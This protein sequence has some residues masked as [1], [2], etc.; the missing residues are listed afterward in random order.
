[1][2]NFLPLIVLV[3]L[4]PDA[5][6]FPNVPAPISV[7]NRLDEHLRGLKSDADE[8]RLRAVTGIRELGHWGRPA[9]PALTA[10]LP[11]ASQQSAKQ[12]IETLGALGP[13]ARRSLPVLLDIVRQPRNG[14]VAATAI[15]IAEIGEPTNPVMVRACLL[16]A[17]RGRAPA[18]L[19]LDLM[20][21]YPRMAAVVADHLQD[22]VPQVRLNA[23][24]AV[25]QHFE[26]EG[27][28]ARSV[29]E[30]LPSGLRQRIKDGLV[31]ALGDS[32]VPVR[33]W[34]I[35]AFMLFE[36]SSAATV[37]PNWIT[38]I[39]RNE[40]YSPGQQGL[41]N[42]GATGARLVIDYLDDPEDRVRESLIQLLSSFRP[43][44]RPTLL[45]AMKHPNPRV[46]EGVIRAVRGSGEPVRAAVEARLI[47][48]DPRVRRAAATA[49]ASINP[50]KARAAIPILVEAAFERDTIVRLNALSTLEIMATFARP[51]VPDMLRRAHTGDLETRFAAAR[52]LAAADRS[53]W[54]TFVPVFID[55]C[56]DKNGAN[57][58]SAARILKSIGP[59]AK[60]ALPA[61]KEMFRDDQAMNRILAADAYARIAPKEVH[62]A[63]KCLIEVLGD[64]AIGVRPRRGI[65]RAT[66]RVLQ[67]LGPV[68]KD[69][70]PALLEVMRSEENP[71][72]GASA[73]IAVIKID[74]ASAAEVYDRFRAE[75]NPV[76]PEPEE[77]WLDFMIQ[78]GKLAKPLIPQMIL[79]L[80]SGQS[81]QQ[82]PV[83]EVLTALGPDA[84]EAIPAL[85]ELEKK[86]KFTDEVAA[87]IKS[88]SGKK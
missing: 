48:E 15:A 23:A 71:H 4:P 34:C 63:V 61:L 2:R 10:L 28:R 81:V 51:A 41:V 27:A 56:H 65:H 24:V 57:R 25:Y 60:A 38:I 67:D 75:L 33:A 83:L 1:M 47:D 6:S 37:M 85:R 44:A 87:A 18:S 22:P 52:V 70:V 19:I 21:R 54:P 7:R 82:V 43:E 40:N 20:A 9:I 16:L 62:V 11:E 17:E 8:D 29:S 12:I 77:A 59:D 42:L 72:V 49:L 14:L 31:A 5:Y 88:V 80:K 32:W 78:L 50:A 45:A 79:V 58:G 76:N 30:S 73:G 35:G 55:V 46:R 74:E 64:G 53:T 36:P 3:C 13:P 86:G 84:A 26:S 66:I 68:A 39:R 69:A